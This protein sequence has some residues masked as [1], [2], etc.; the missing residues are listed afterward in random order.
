MHAK[1]EARTFRR[2]SRS[3]RHCVDINGCRRLERHSKAAN[4]LCQHNDIKLIRNY[5]VSNTANVQHMVTLCDLQF[6]TYHSE[7]Y[8]H[9]CDK[10]HSLAYSWSSL[11]LSLRQTFHMSQHRSKHLLAVH[12]ISKTAPLCTQKT[13]LHRPDAKGLGQNH[14]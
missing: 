13:V 7:V 6:E 2:F 5:R 14:P 4:C 9:L 1:A 10:M 3:F 11:R 8:I 12:G